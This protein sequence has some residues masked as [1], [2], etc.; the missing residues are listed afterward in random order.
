LTSYVDGTST[1]T[2]QSEITKRDN[3][4]LFG[5]GAVLKDADGNYLVVSVPSAQYTEVSQSDTAN[6]DVLKNTGTYGATG[7]SLGYAAEF[8]FIAKP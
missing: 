6:G 5:L 7:K 8:N 2:A 1:T 4:T 3:E